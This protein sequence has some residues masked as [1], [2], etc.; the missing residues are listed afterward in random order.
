MTAEWERAIRNSD[1]DALDR[2]VRDGANLD[3][4]D[5]HGQT[6]LMVA[7]RDGRPMVVQFLLDRGAR[8][9]HTAK[10]RLSAVMLAVINHHA[11]VV[12]M[13]VDAGADLDIRG[14]SAGFYDKTARDLAIGDE[15]AQLLEALDSE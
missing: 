3:A 8:L 14:S 4:R 10:H 9:D 6:G 13:L 7:A 11:D 2:Q 1:V 12:R 15:R 5:H